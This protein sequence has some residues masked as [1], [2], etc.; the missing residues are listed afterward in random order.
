[1][2]NPIQPRPLASVPGQPSNPGSSVPT[3][4]NILPRPVP[5]PYHSR[6][7]SFCRLRKHIAAAITLI[8]LT[9]TTVTLLPSFWGAKYGKDALELARW[10][11]RKDYI[12]AC[13][14][15]SDSNPGSGLSTS[16]FLIPFS[17]ISIARVL[18]VNG[19]W[20]AKC[21]RPLA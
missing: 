7:C 9:L 10:T 2:S 21:L 19:L 13:Q 4:Q 11:A 15:V 17:S 1:M 8:T 20:R 18:V 16:P 5:H 12:E 14:E 3:T 6:F